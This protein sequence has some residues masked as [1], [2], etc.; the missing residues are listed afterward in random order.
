MDPGGQG[1][2]KCD[3]SQPEPEQASSTHP[4]RK[5]KEDS[6]EKCVN[7]LKQFHKTKVNSDVEETRKKMRAYVKENVVP[8]I[9]R[10]RDHKTTMLF[11][12]SGL[13]Q[14]P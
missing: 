12:E 6:L 3:F 13:R 11:M 7:I 2:S 5:A 8:G 9:R 4:A 10:S 1:R 14:R